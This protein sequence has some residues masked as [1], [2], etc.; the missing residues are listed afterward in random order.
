MTV[1]C[2]DSTATTSCDLKVV[3]GWLPGNPEFKQK[4]TGMDSTMTPNQ[5]SGGC[6]VQFALR[7]GNQTFS[8]ILL[9]NWSYFNNSY[10]YP[11]MTFSLEEYDSRK[12]IDITVILTIA[13][14]ASEKVE[15][16]LSTTL[17]LHFEDPEEH[18]G[19]LSIVYY[20][21]S[22]QWLQFLHNGAAIL[23]SEKP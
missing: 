21:N 8:N 14:K 2:N 23:I 19:E 22:E 17:N 11:A 9:Y 16:N 18:C 13:L 6:D 7:I 10:Y 3:K 20:A 15:I 12:A 4:A 1:P 5:I